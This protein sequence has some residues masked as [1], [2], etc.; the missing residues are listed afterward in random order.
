M[1]YGL[2]T[3]RLTTIF[4]TRR[5]RWGV[6]LLILT[7]SITPATA[8]SV[9]D[10]PHIADVKFVGAVGFTQEI[11]Q[12]SI[13][14]SPNRRFLGFRGVYWWLWLYRVGE[15]GRLG[16]RL[17]RALMSI[18]EPPSLLDETLLA[19]DLERLRIFFE[20]EGY[21][22]ANIV[23][24]VEIHGQRATVTFHIDQGPSTVISR[25]SYTG[26]DSLNVQQQQELAHTSIFPPLSDQPLLNYRSVPQRFQERKL[27]E[28]RQRILTLLRNMGYA[29]VT[30]DSIRAIVTPTATDSFDVELRIQTGRRFRHGPV[31]FEVQGPE[32]DATRRMDTLRSGV[33]SII[34]GDTRI[35][36]SLLIKSLRIHP[37]HWYNQSDIQATKRQLEATGIF[38]FTDIV[39]QDPV[40]WILPHRITV[41][42][43]PRHQF[44]LST[45]VRQ[46][47]DA[48][49]D[50]GNEL[51]G[52]LGMTYK[53]AN[54]FGGGEAFSL[55][56]TASV[57]ADLDTTLFSST[58]AEFTAT[59]SLPYLLL[60]SRHLDA[61][62]TRTRFTFSYLT[63]RRE[64]LSLIIRGRAAA[65]IRF[66]LQH[67]PNLTSTIDLMDLSL[68]QPDTL[69][70]FE[71]RFLRRILGTEEDSQII[72][73][74]QRAQILEDYTQPQINNAI[75]YIIRSERGNPLRKD[76][77][78]SYEASIE[79]G[80]MLPYVLDRYVFTPGR[81]E[82]SLHLF[83][84]TGSDSEVTYRQYVR[85][86]G[87]FR[88]YYRLSNRTVFATKFLGG[89]VY[90]VGKS[91]VAPFTHRFYSG[92]ASSVR[93]WGLRQLGPGSANFKQLTSNRR[94]TNL[95]GGDIKLEASMELRQTALR[96]RLGADWI[97]A[98]FTDA[99]N[100][101]FGPRNPGFTAITPDQP[102]GRFTL[103]NLLRETGVGCG[104][105]IRV[106]WPYVIVRL[107]M[108]VRAYDPANPDADLFPTGLRDW[109]GYFR[110]GH[111]F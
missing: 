89:W 53:N 1:K 92:G 97:L 38:S 55:G 39:S 100:V 99:G 27:I 33:T 94:E 107:D 62:Q 5:S 79:L 78:H 91:T 44:L 61:F 90:P 14:T 43:R 77:G 84:F 19:A 23:P 80:G 57:A 65:R 86:V 59:V 41:R 83:S 85:V 111:A 49:G 36:N 2:T 64:D 73:P 29:S 3:R 31:M 87:S 63:A 51:G 40:D 95:L 88:R 37:N 24:H 45:F 69:G 4:T 71:S 47:N 56:A 18:G 35:K 15:R 103:Q 11:L 106:S 9:S 28:E 101:W 72:D 21:L 66:E 110:L 82:Q 17:S 52:G 96:D 58:L 12:N 46:I 7:G 109:H 68:S 30:R 98:T 70:G 16:S 8:Q 54:M 20:R 22:Q 93:G 81:Q 75:R 74:V 6:W 108:A 32:R 48:L 34:E 42:T 67:T 102:T 10:P 25:V 50:V 105:G 13:Q 104:V 26:L 60:P 76:G